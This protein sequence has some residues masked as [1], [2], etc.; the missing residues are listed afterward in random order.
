MARCT[1]CSRAVT[2]TCVLV[3]G[4]CSVCRNAEN[5]VAVEKKVNKPKDITCN[6]EEDK[7]KKMLKFYEELYRGDI[8]NKQVS[9]AF[10]K[11]Q[12]ASEDPCKYA[13]RIRGTENEY[14]ALNV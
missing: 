3:D 11:A 13:E 14:S 8:K 9:I 12:L 7:A 5:Y 2:C 1:G 6:F 4:Y 10:L